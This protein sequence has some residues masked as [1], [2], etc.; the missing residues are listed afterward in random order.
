M[1]ERAA[2][3]SV[4]KGYL[5]RI[6]ECVSRL[7]VQTS[8]GLQ[9]SA[10]AETKL[11]VLVEVAA[12]LEDKTVA[13]AILLEL[14]RLSCALEA[15]GHTAASQTLQSVL[16]GSAAALQVFV[17]ARRGRAAMFVRFQPTHGSTSMKRAP[18]FDDSAPKQ[19]LL[20]RELFPSGVSHR[21]EPGPTSK[22]RQTY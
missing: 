15:G 6:L 12:R 3:N 7:L 17:E 1:A 22:S 18:R 4:P 20:L 5:S 10:D 11:A 8:D 19:G 16:S 13:E 9:F 21:I 2:A 14:V